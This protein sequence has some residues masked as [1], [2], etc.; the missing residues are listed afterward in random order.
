MN[1]NVA[2]RSVATETSVQDIRLIA[3]NGDAQNYMDIPDSVRIEF[4]LSDFR[5]RWLDDTLQVQVRSIVAFGDQEINMVT[6]EGVIASIELLYEV[7]LCTSEQLPPENEV[8]PELFQEILDVRVIPALYPYVRA[9]VH[10]LSTELPLP[11]TLIPLDIVG[12][13]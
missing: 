1:Q 2:K 6:G 11:T 4:G 10:T 7:D 12:D 8:S 13:Q 5:H 9:K 3:L